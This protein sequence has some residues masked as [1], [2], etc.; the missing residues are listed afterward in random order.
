MSVSKTALS[1]TVVQKPQLSTPTAA[2]IVLVVIVV[3]DTF[4]APLIRLTLNSGMPP[5]VIAGLRMML[6]WLIFTPFILWKHNRDL[7]RLSRTDILLM[8]AAGGG[9]AG[10][11]TL[12]FMAV[13]NTSILTA[14]VIFSTLMLWVAAMETALLKA[15]LHRLV[16]IGLVLVFAGSVVISIG[17]SH[18]DNCDD[19]AEQPTS[20]GEATGD[21]TLLGIVLALGSSV[22]GAT[23]M[24]I[25]RKARERLA[26]APY[27]WGVY[28]GGAVTSLTIIAMTRTPITGYSTEAY[29][30]MLVLLL[31][32]QF[33]IHGGLSYIVGHISATFISISAQTVVV[34]S[35]IAAYF[36][37][38]EVPQSLEIAGSVVIMSGIILAI[39]G[40]RNKV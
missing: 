11:I 29:F 1:P 16:L 23:Y 18:Q 4:S 9:F 5:L 22:A 28:S 8:A 27:M 33:A 26:A 2:Y 24:V 17:S 14:G 19:P 20:S 31:L 37:F 12:A 32:A 7:R 36:L 6:S 13:D 25:G 10:H 15:R 39:L 21:K 30:W 40:Q 38:A 34:T 35:A 3:L